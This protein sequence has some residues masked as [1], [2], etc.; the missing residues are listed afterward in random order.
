MTQRQVE[1]FCLG[2]LSEARSAPYF[3]HLLICAR[4]RS[5]VKKQDTYIAAMRKATAKLR[6][7]AD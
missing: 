1:R 7:L 3:D 2:N 4:C 5:L 6:R